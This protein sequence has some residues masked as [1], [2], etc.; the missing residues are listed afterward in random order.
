MTESSATDRMR[1]GSAC[2]QQADLAAAVDDAVGALRPA[3][4][5]SRPVDLVLAFF[6]APHLPAAEGLAAMVRERLGPGCFA[7][8]S[9]H[10]VVSAEHEV[11]T[12][13]ALSVLAAQLPGVQ[14]SPFLLPQGE[15]NASGPES[16]PFEVLAPGAAG[17]ELVLL[18]ADPFTLDS[19][20]VLHGFHHGAPGVRVVGGM[21]SAGPTPNSNLLI[22]NDWASRSGGFAIALSGNLR[23]DVVVSQGC[24][25][26][27]PALEVTSVEGNLLHTLD[28]LPALERAEQVLRALPESERERLQHGLYVGRPARGAAAGTGDWLIRN[29]LG[30][31]RERGVLA[32]GDLIGEREKIRFHVRDAE[33][34][35][36]DLE[37]LL[38]P[39]V[40]DVRPAAALLFACNSRGRGLY[41]QPDGDVSILRSVLGDPVPAAGM[42]C[43]GEIG[44]VGDRNFVHG[45]TASLA[46]IRPRT[47][48]A[49]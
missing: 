4:D 11:E 14:V 24:R 12:G 44:P 34:A 5:P 47:L 25:P 35:R 9:A 26:V 45:H 30:A 1:W 13:P 23:V 6:T 36:E 32:V 40:V 8:V 42:F 38:S 7:A 21:A 15:W 19:E 17:A 3:L 46:L 10:G 49:N 31:D 39:Q 18:I 37:M 29:L 2:S 48:S 33:T 20:R 22:L 16:L 28:G 27:G 43:A 41:G